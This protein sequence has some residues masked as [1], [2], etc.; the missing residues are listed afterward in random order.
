MPQG[1]PKKTSSPAQ[2]SPKPAMLKETIT[3]PDGQIVQITTKPAVSSNG[4]KP[5]GVTAR[6]RRRH[7]QTIAAL[8]NTDD[9]VKA[10]VG[11][12]VTF[13]REHA[14]VGLAV[15]FII[16][17]QAQTVV[18][19]LVASFIDPLIQLF[20]GGTDLGNLTVTFHLFG[21]HSEFSYGAMIYALINLMAVLVTIYVLIKA[22]KLDKLDAPKK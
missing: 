8:M 10:Q 1:Q 19:Q 14:I 13:I 9:I 3:T 20:I 18:K 22:F 12:F 5:H 16:G 11:G 21:N 6:T 4:T 2:A 7:K 15:G 17:M